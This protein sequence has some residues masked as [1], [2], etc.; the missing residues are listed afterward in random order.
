VADSESSIEEH[1]DELTGMSPPGCVIIII[2]LLGLAP[3][4]YLAAQDNGPEG[5][6]NNLFGNLNTAQTLSTAGMRP[7]RR[8]APSIALP[9]FHCTLYRRNETSK[10][11]GCEL[12]DQARIREGGAVGQA[13]VSVTGG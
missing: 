5:S 12:L 3:A 4:G 8:P 13:E 2:H 10:A 6:P 1:R 7:Q 11:P 9:S